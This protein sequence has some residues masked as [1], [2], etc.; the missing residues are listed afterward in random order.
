[1]AGSLVKIIALVLLLVSVLIAGPV[2]QAQSPE[3][4]DQDAALHAELIGAPVFAADGVQIGKVADIAYDEEDQPKR[5]RMTSGSV[6]GLGSRTIEIPSGLF[7]VLRG[8][9]VVDL[10]A[11]A[12]ETLP[13]LVEQEEER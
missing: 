4:A 10:P 12:I 6:L 7:T 2:G 5:I 8:A 9:V 1:M 3:S 13:E 11:E